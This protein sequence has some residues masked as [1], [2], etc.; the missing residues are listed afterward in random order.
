MLPTFDD[1]LW[2]R[3]MG[4]VGP[5][6]RVSAV[7]AKSL[8]IGARALDDG[9]WEKNPSAEKPKTGTWFAMLLLSTLVVIM[10]APVLGSLARQW[11]DDPNYGHG[12]FVPL[13]AA[14]VLWYE[15]ERLRALPARRLPFRS[16][17][18]SL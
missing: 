2:L 8:E 12:F 16:A 10:Y 7:S 14:Y 9:A 17:I 11:W 3:V 6:A 15:R 4:R 18:W 1:I 5:P 13:F